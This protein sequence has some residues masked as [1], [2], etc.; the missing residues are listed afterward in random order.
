MHPDSGKQASPGGGLQENADRAL[1]WG[2]ATI[3]RMGCAGQPDCGSQKKN[4]G[5]P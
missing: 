4:R 2:A 5:E 1:S 3:Y